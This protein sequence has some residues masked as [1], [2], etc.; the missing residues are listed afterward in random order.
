MF[1][2]RFSK[3]VSDTNLNSPVTPM[4]GDRS[5]GDSGNSGSNTTTTDTSTEH[6]SST[7]PS[8]SSDVIVELTKTLT[9]AMAQHDLAT[10]Q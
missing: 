7:D 1:T 6:A 9:K 5:L 2:H 8:T 4:S 3:K 10:F